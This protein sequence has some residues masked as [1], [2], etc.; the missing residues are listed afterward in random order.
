MQCVICK[1][2]TTQKGITTV[3]LEREGTTLVFKGVPSEICVNCGESYL[4]AK[5]SS[6]LLAKAESAAQE[7]IELGVREFKAA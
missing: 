3:T 2:G 5:T 7:G 1:K 4:D 6:A